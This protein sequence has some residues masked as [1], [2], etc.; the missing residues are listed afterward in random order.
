MSIKKS[1]ICE[2]KSESRPWLDIQTYWPLFV[3]TQIWRSLPIK[4]VHA[5]YVSKYHF[6][7][8]TS[9]PPCSPKQ[10]NLSNEKLHPSFNHFTIPLLYME[11]QDLCMYVCSRDKPQPDPD[12][13]TQ[14]HI[15]VNLVSGWVSA[16]FARQPLHQFLLSTSL[17]RYRNSRECWCAWFHNALYFFRLAHIL[18]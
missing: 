6:Q 1:W 8:P 13:D 7:V 18:L 5:M 9:L 11:R 15:P 12:F 17:G 2:L 16:I 3:E 10:N 4:M 14:L